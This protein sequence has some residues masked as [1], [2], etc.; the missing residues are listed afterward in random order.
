VQAHVIFAHLAPAVIGKSL[1]RHDA[2]AGFPA[3]LSRVQIID[4]KNGSWPI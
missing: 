4:P 2:H 3:E 1:D